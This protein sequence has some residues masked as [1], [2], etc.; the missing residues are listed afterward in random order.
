M[1]KN[2]YAIIGSLFLLSSS[3]G[4]PAPQERKEL[5]LE[6]TY[7]H[8]VSTLKEYILKIGEKQEKI[9]PRDTLETITTHIQSMSS[10]NGVYA[11]K[12]TDKTKEFPDE[13]TTIY[14]PHEGEARYIFGDIRV[15]GGITSAYVLSKETLKD[16]LIVLDELTAANQKSFQELYKKQINALHD[17]IHPKEQ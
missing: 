2:I 3:C 5:V 14:K 9:N 4:E 17:L 6:K 10:L 7:A 1:T 13:L 8:K 15:D 16:S 11:F 12:L